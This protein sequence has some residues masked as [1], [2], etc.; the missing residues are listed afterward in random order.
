[1]DCVHINDQ[2]IVD[3]IIVIDDFT[4]VEQNF[5]EQVNDWVIVNSSVQPE[6]GVIGGVG[7]TY[8]RQLNIFIAPQPYPS[9]S[10]SEF[11]KWRAPTPYPGIEG[12]SSDE[13]WWNEE[14][15]Q[16]VKHVE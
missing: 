13:Y 9:W 8:N 6:Y 5:P 4:F 14:T 2:N 7:A 10:L 11:Y 1:M 16:W 3:N 15:Q 12:S